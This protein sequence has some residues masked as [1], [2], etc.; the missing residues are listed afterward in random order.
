MRIVLLL[1]LALSVGYLGGYLAVV[2]AC[3]Q[4]KMELRGVVDEL[5]SEL[6]FTTEDGCRRLIQE[7][8]RLEQLV[9]NV[10]GEFGAGVH[11][12]DLLSNQEFTSSV[13]RDLPQQR[14]E[15][16]LP[17]WA[18]ATSLSRQGRTSTQIAKELN[19]GLGEVELM[20]K[21]SQLDLDYE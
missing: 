8:S 14:S 10:R 16:E 19:L 17:L 18:E 3:R 4:E 7:R 5:L 20:L 15:T 11:T 9:Q 12:G 1:V 13:P 21:V 6:R 2:Y